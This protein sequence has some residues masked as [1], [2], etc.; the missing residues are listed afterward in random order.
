MFTGLIEEI[1]TVR[2]IQVKTRSAVLTIKAEKVL[3]DAKIGDS[4]STNGVCLTVSSM[5]DGAFTVDVMPETMGKT[6]LG[7]LKPGSRV[8]LERAARV[9]DRLGGHIVSGHVDGTGIISSVTEEENAFKVRIQND[10]NLMKYIIA[11]GSVAVDGTSLTVAGLGDSWFEVSIIPHTRENTTLLSKRIG[12]E[13]NL[14]FDV[15]GKYVER[16]M[17]PREAAASSKIDM[18]FLGENGFL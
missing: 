4:I 1:G 10:R 17:D 16:L 3:E 13:L 15:I 9:G 6:N 14:E 18:N 2:N 12:E 8:N 7:K 11:Q 5:A